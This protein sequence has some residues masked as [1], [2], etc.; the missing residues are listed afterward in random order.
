MYLFLLA[1]TNKKWRFCVTRDPVPLKL[2][3]SPTDGSCVK[4]F[5]FPA[6]DNF[7]VFPNSTPEYLVIGKI[8]LGITCVMVS[9]IS[10][11]EN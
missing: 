6:S 9:L 8:Q 1:F 10:T 3:D 11:Y 5:Y 4:H 7:V 2:C